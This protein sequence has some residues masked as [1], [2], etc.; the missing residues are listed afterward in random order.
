MEINSEVPLTKTGPSFFFLVV[1]LPLSS[2]ALFYFCLIV[3]E[4]DIY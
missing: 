3:S 4:V 1:S 2:I